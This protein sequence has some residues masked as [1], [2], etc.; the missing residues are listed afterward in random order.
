MIIP[1]QLLAARNTDLANTRAILVAL[2]AIGLLGACG[3]GDAPGDAPA[4]TPEGNEMTFDSTLDVDLSAMERSATGL[5]TRDLTVGSGDV[6]NP[7]DTVSVHYTGWLPNGQQFDSSRGGAPFQFHLGAGRVIDGW[8][9]GVAGMRIGGRRQLVIPSD[10]AY[11][12][13]GAGGVI[14]P[15]ATLVFDVELLGV[16]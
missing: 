12:E 15:G 11:R 8:D 1:L 6:A 7:G 2:V 16:D 5:Y 14:P 10:L 3:G 9:E 4:G 13:Q